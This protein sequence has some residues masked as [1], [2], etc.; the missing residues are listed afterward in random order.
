LEDTLE[1]LRRMWRDPGKVSYAGKHYQ[2][3]DAYCEPKP[4]PI[5]HLIVG[6]GGDKTMRLAAQ[7]ADGWNLPDAPIER[8]RVRHMLLQKHCEALGRDPQSIE[9]SWFGRLAVAR[10][11]DQALA[12]SSGR[13]N[14]SN[15]FVGTPQQAVELMQPFVER[16]VS[17]FM[18]EVLGLP[19]PDIIGMVL[20][21]VL[22]KVRA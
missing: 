8:Y 15:A 6:G 17:Y 10:T 19:D 4:D 22:P 18:L 5:P 9:L 14:R 1:I 3:T 13:W 11:E 16:G 21:E 7:Y 2:I 12:L 20:E